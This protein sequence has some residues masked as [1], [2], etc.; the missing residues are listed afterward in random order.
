MEHDGVWKQKFL[1]DDCHLVLFENKSRVI[2]IAG[3][4]KV[5]DLVILGPESLNKINILTMESTI[6]APE[7]AHVSINTVFGAWTVCE[8]N[9]ELY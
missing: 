2:S 3:W 9:F 8:S 4:T 5:N 7:N 1:P 6:F